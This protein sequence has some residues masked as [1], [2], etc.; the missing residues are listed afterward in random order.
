LDDDDRKSGEA[1]PKPCDGAL[2]VQEPVIFES[3]FFNY[4]HGRLSVPQ[5]Q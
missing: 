3:K 4:G 5:R 2:A 1:N